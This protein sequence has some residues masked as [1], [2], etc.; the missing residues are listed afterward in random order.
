MFI[1][2]ICNFQPDHKADLFF[3]KLIG[4]IN[5]ISLYDFQQCLSIFDNKKMLLCRV[6][7]VYTTC[8]DIEV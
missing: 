6:C 1:E 8:Q 2:I 4:T 7:C 3:T 5:F